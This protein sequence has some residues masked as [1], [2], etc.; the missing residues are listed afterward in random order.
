MI[1]EAVEE[2]RS[3]VTETDKRY[4]NLLW[5]MP[6]T[7]LDGNK[8]MATLAPNPRISDASHR[9]SGEKNIDGVFLHKRQKDLSVVMESFRAEVQ[10]GKGEI[11]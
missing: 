3:H 7:I 10:N 6:Y 9:K 4:S 1:R 2:I 11:S 8:E 5:I